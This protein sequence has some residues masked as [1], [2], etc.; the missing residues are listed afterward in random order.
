MRQ[1]TYADVDVAPTKLTEVRQRDGRMNRYPPPE[2]WDDWSEPDGAAWPERVDRR[3]RCIPTICFNCESACGL[4][5]FVDKQSGEIAKFE[6]NPEH[7]LSNGRL[8][9]RG[10]G[11]TGLLYD[12]DRLKKPLVRV[13][14]Q[15]EHLDADLEAVVAAGCYGVILPMAE[16][17]D[18]IRHTNA[19]MTAAEAACGRAAGSTSLMLQ[20][21]TALG[22]VRC[23]ELATATDRLEAVIFGS[24]ED[25]DLQGDLKCDWSTEGIE[26]L[27]ARSKVLADG[28]AAKLPLVLDG[29]FSD[30]NDADKLRAFVGMY[31]DLMLADSGLSKLEREMIAV[32]VSAGGTYMGCVKYHAVFG[33]E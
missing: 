27:Y 20:I 16:S 1:P 2:R 31:N 17:V 14:N 11:G 21:E 4:L 5:A 8:C 9:P 12:P 15:P 6:G 30:V 23:Y 22:V 18:N 13:N 29:A 28:R 19:V 25:G 32:A 3:Y 24:A 10:T 26:L 33:V 7:P